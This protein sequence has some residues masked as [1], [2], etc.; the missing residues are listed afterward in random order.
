MHKKI[1]HSPSAFVPLSFL[2]NVE[3]YILFFSQFKYSNS[4]LRLQ[5]LHLFAN[6]SHLLI[7]YR[8]ERSAQKSCSQLTKPYILEKFVIRQM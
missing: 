2:K 7:G 5:I 1:M 8:I 6:F 3:A 4:Y